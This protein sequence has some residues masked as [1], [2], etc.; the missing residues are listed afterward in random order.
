MAGPA[1]VAR[2]AGA[3]LVH[4][5]RRVVAHFA[6][7]RGPGV[8]LVVRITP[9]L[10]EVTTPRVPWAAD[11]SQGLLEVL[12]TLDAAARDANI[13]GVLLRFSGTPGGWSR[14][15]SLRRAVERVREAGK[16]VAVYADSLD[17]GGMLLASAGS[18]LWIPESGSLML[19]GPSLVA[20]ISRL[21]W[22]PEKYTRQKH[23]SK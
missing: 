6:L 7:P 18:S 19:V 5:A 15:L 2:N 8:W 11:G 1:R 12:Q 9:G 4:T 14:L 17:A 10:R 22:T 3:N 23:F 16:P 13:D 21:P 20:L